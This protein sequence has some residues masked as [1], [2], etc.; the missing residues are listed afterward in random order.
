[1]QRGIVCRWKI[2]CLEFQSTGIVRVSVGAGAVVA[3]VD[4]VFRMIV[5]YERRFGDL[6]LGD[7]ERRK[8]T[9]LFEVVPTV[10]NLNIY[11]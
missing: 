9:I 2:S 1:M 3:V 6:F 10:I 11:I 5:N 8:R 4:I 7:T